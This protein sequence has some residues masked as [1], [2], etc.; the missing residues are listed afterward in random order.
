MTTSMD[1]RVSRETLLSLAMQNNM[2]LDTVARLPTYTLRQKL[3]RMTNDPTPLHARL[4]D[5]DGDGDGDAT[6]SFPVTVVPET[7]VLATATDTVRPQQHTHHRTVLP[8]FSTH[9]T[10]TALN[11]NTSG[12]GGSS[13]IG[14]LDADDTQTVV[15]MAHVTDTTN[16]ADQKIARFL[17]LQ[18]AK[19]SLRAANRQNV[20]LKNMNK[21]ALAE[22]DLTVLNDEIATNCRQVAAIENETIEIQVW[23]EEMQVQQSMFYQNMISHCVD[24]SGNVK[25]H[26]EKKLQALNEYSQFVSQHTTQ[27]EGLE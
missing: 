8:S 4:G 7:C 17:F 13:N 23:F 27:D 2:D 15:D 1:N 18:D 24:L 20:E 21:Q 9:V 6:T 19:Q 10:T 12:G 3:A 22:D 14:L 5:G 11:E 26:F 16:P 25:T